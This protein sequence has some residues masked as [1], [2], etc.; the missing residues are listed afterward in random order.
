LT[1]YSWLKGVRSHPLASVLTIALLVR[2]ALVPLFYDDFNYWGLGVFS[3]LLAHGNDPY[4]AVV[5]DPTLLWINPWRY[6]PLYL[7]FSVPAFLLKT[8]SANGMMYLATLKI[9]LV[10]ADLVTTLF[11][12]KSLELMTSHRTAVRLSALYA[13]NPI[14]IF[15]S[16]VHGTNDP[17]AIMFTVMSF[18]YFLRYTKSSDTPLRQD[19]AKSA[20]LLGL[21]IATKFYPLF[22]VPVFLIALRG[23]SSRLLHLGLSLLPLAV[24]SL[25]FL[26]WNPSSY[27]FLLTVNNVGGTHPLFPLSGVPSSG[28]ILLVVLAAVLLLVYRL[29][30]TPVEK[31]SLVFLWVGLAVLAGSYNY[32]A[33]GIP[34]F[35][36]FLAEHRGK[37]RGM[38]FYPALALLYFL[39]FNGPYNAAAG[40]TGPYYLT[41]P[42]FNDLVVVARAFPFVTTVGPWLI[43]ASLAVTLYYFASVVMVSLRKGGVPGAVQGAREDGQ[44]TP[45]TFRRAL[46]IALIGLTVLSWG[47]ATAYARFPART[48]P[49]VNGTTLEFTSSFN[50]QLIDYQWVFAGEGTYQVNSSSGY[51]QISAVG[52][53][54]Q[55][56]LYRGWGQVIDGF[57][58][59]N[60]TTV[61]LD[62][63]FVGFAQNASTMIITRMNGGWFGAVMSGGST[64]FVYFD[65]VSGTGHVLAPAD[66]GWH[67]LEVSFTGVQRIVR[68][69]NATLGLSGITFTRLILGNPDFTPGVGGYVQFSN[70]TVTQTDFPSLP[71]AWY[72]AAVSLFAPLGAIA[73]VFILVRISGRPPP[74]LR[75]P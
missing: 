45:S 74:V 25:P 43:A 52:N 34:F 30:L 27:L 46:I 71:S 61:D 60:A 62:F 40:A 58:A 65:D 73:A 7:L 13:L 35:T 29:S 17:I 50:S 11:L 4:F 12:Y 38:V 32:M 56:Y 3:S 69:E 49:T 28:P 53:Y 24:F 37:L 10:L 15:L 64:N 33:W 26:L 31:T 18:Y 36:L 22:L 6:P 68:F 47:A 8:V 63:R 23:R 57:Q 72:L 21:G 14:V 9:P 55:A 2:L 19:L 16:A 70:A 51:I 67:S 75:S 1:G 20:L 42:L 39:T 54:D 66:N 41:Y 44:G 5:K 48:Y 59:S